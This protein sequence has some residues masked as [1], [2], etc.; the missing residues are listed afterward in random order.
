MPPSFRVWEWARKAQEQGYAENNVIDDSVIEERGERDKRRWENH[1]EGL[2]R[3]YSARKKPPAIPKFSISPPD[4]VQSQTSKIEMDQIQE[5]A[6]PTQIS[7]VDIE[8][9]A[10]RPSD[11]LIEPL[12]FG[13]QNGVLGTL[14]TLYRDP[15][16]N[17]TTSSIGTTTTGGYSTGT[18][19]ESLSDVEDDRSRPVEENAK[20]DEDQDNL[21]SKKTRGRC[22]TGLQSIVSQAQDSNGPGRAPPQKLQLIIDKAAEEPAPNPLTG[23]PPV[24]TLEHQHSI[25]CD[26]SPV[27]DESE[28]PSRVF[29]SPYER[30][31]Q[32]LSAPSSALHLPLPDHLHLPHLPPSAVTR[33]SGGVVAALLATSNNLAGAATPAANTIAP[34]I[35]RHGYTLSRY[36]ISTPQRPPII[37]TTSGDPRFRAHP[38]SDSLEKEHLQDISSDDESKQ[39]PQETN[40]IS[41]TDTTKVEHP[42]FQKLKHS[43][44]INWIPQVLSRPGSR[45]PSV[46]GDKEKTDASHKHTNNSSEVSLSGT[47]QE[48]LTHRIEKR[49]YQRAKKEKRRQAQI[50]ITKHI[51]EV[52]QRQEFIMKFARAHMMF[53]GPGHRLQ[54]QVQVA[55]R[56]LDLQ[57]STVYLPNVL[58]VSFGDESTSTSNV[59]IIQQSG[60]LNLEKLSMM[61][62]LFWKVLHIFNNCDVPARIAQLEFI[63]SGQVIYDEISVSSASAALDLLMQSPQRYG[64]RKLILFGGLASSAICTISFSGSFADALIAFPM[65]CLLVITQ[66][67]SSKNE[68]YSNVFEIT[69]ATV[70]SFLSAA[71]A[72]SG[73]FCYAALASSSVVL[74]LP[75]F[76]VLSGSLELASKQIVSGAVR[77]CFAAIYSLFLG[78]G[79][80]IGAQVFT[81]MTNLQVVGPDDF[82][83]D[84]AHEPGAPWWNRKPSLWW[85]FLT[86]PLYSLALSLLNQAPLWR[87]EMLITLIISCGGWSAN[88]WAG[89]AFHG[90]SDIQSALGAFAVGV[91]ANLYAR[92]F[93]GNA[94]VV[95]ITGILFQLPSGLANGGLLTFA[96]ADN[97]E[98]GNSNFSSYEAGFQ[99]AIQLIAVAIGLTVGLF[100]AAVVVHPFGRG[101]RRMGALFSL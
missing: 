78:F 79:I 51:A 13:R 12:P 72:S 22:Q 32:S 66:T 58:L 23:P 80:A 33:S 88:H 11:P 40:G 65:G 15:T 82:L 9:E 75:G 3:R 21:V 96:A 44:F 101:K 31:K 52:L 34:N 83:C 74:I 92:F 57:I 95:M 42:S 28:I 94:Y 84:T 76:F 16:F 8:A 37:R 68:L 29:M 55:A 100:T 86:V 50:Y 87:K 53:A 64:R 93:Y 59:K 49:L 7:H 27:S 73:K 2:V 4:N 35:S 71:L 26:E 45:A 85:A 19:I 60:S 90:R 14:L 10:G 18:D 97:S 43:S 69:I 47:E 1:A 77:I 62:E 54:S 81:Q 56:V 36:E 25:P 38:H 17:K 89:V 30:L 6:S 46:I 5:E 70:L 20:D 63:R 39:V 99:V 41:I 91:A 67:L 61:H 98:T 24:D 48:V